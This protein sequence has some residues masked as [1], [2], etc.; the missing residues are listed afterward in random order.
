LEIEIVLTAFRGEYDHDINKH[1][2]YRIKP[3]AKVH[4]ANHDDDDYEDSDDD[5]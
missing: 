3:T 1:T 4:S 5:D 2:I